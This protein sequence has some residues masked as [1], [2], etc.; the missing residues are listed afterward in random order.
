MLGASASLDG[1]L[2]FRVE[3]FVE[4]FSG[5]GLRACGVLWV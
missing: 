2:P 3:G 1:G 5:F 4:I